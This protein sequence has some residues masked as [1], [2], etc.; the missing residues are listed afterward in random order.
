MGT[1]YFFLSFAITALPFIVYTM[2]N[3]D[4]V[5][6]RTTGVSIIDLN[7][8]PSETLNIL[9]SQTK[10]VLQMFSVPGKGDWNLRHNIPNRPI[11]DP[12][13]TTVFIIGLIVAPIKLGRHKIAL[14][15]KKHILDNKFHK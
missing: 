11:F 4:Q 13:I 12:I 6:G 3:Q 7:D 1:V 9:A 5:L 10:I 8:E 15:S 14:I 2:N